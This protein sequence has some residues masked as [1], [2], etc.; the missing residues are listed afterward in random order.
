[1]LQKDLNQENKEIKDMAYSLY[2]KHG[3]KDGNQFVDWLEAERMTGK[4]PRVARSDPYRNLLYTLLFLSLLI[5]AILLFMLYRG[6]PQSEL[7]E[8]SMEQ[9]HAGGGQPTPM[10]MAQ[11]PEEKVLIFGD[12]HFEYGKSAL[13]LDAKSILDQNIQMLKDHPEVKV[14]MAGYTSASGTERVNQKL[15]ETRAN[16]VRGYLIQQG[17]E[18]NR[19]TVIGYG[20]TNPARYEKYPKMIGSTAAKANMRVLFEV[21]VR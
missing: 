11:V 2:A 3:F 20:K 15:S 16:S 5:L 18:A 7:S 1:M 17:I 14:R 8:R 9:I 10:V 19:L 4:K 13:A 21:V 6:A 12:T